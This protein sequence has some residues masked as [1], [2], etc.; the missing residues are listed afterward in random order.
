MICSIH[1]IKTHLN[2][3]S[4]HRH[5]ITVAPP[6]EWPMTANL[7]KSIQFCKE[8]IKQ[9]RVLDLRRPFP[10]TKCF[11]I[12]HAL[13]TYLINLFGMTFNF[14]QSNSES[15]TFCTAFPE[16]MSM[17]RSKALMHSSALCFT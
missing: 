12:I 9:C 14:D 11:Y 3:T 1:I 10:S 5:S 4:L 17:R 8:E 13:I 2:L 7:H 16:L 15:K 6:K